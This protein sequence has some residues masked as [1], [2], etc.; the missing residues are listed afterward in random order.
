M[1]RLASPSI[2]SFERN[3]RSGT[4]ARHSR[5]SDVHC[6]EQVLPSAARNFE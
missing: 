6:T 5:Q 3:R 2:T 1:N 4:I